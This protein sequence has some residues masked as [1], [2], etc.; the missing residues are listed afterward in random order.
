MYDIIIIGGGASG[1]MCAMTAS[2][3]QLKTLILD[4]NPTPAKKL[5][6]T[7][8]GKCN[9]TNI[10]MS[11]KYYNVNIDK[12]LSRFSEKDAI[13]FFA[14]LG[15]VTYVDDVGRVYPYSN[16][17]RSVIDIIV[18]QLDNNNVEYIGNESVVKISKLSNFWH[19]VT[20]NTEFL[21]KNIVLSCG[22]TLF[23]CNEKVLPFYPSLCALK[24]DE[25]T[26]KLSGI[27]LSDV[28][29]TAKCGDKSMSDKGEVLFK[30]DG[31]SGIVIFNLSCLFARSK[32]FSGDV[33]IDLMPDYSLQKVKEIIL[34]RITKFGQDCFKGLF[35]DEIAKCICK[36]AGVDK[37]T[38]FC[39]DKLAYVIK[40]LTFNVVGYYDNNQV[41][42]GGISLTSLDNNLQSKT[43]K[44]LYV[45]GEICDVDGEC[46]GYNLQ[47][48]WTSGY[49]VGSSV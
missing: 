28:V 15:L 31:L 2:A 34:S 33:K 9:L 18:N 42:S 24:V 38:K 16:S 48:A 43:Q 1:T 32:S 22:G 39:V 17:A 6:V 30:D 29:V 11:S 8:N 12:Y 25:S 35:V 36:K 13:E 37:L 26:K 5:M 40:N 21:T 46:G 27:R 4:K 41:F 47:W 7:G 23:E 20:K 10:N 14:K 3:R 44:G 49:I 19:V 45:V